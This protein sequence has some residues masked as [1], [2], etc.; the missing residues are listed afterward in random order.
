MEYCFEELYFFIFFK[1]EKTDLGMLTG[2]K[3]KDL[4]CDALLHVNIKVV[5]NE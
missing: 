4:N 5:Y 1:I 3:V 2:I